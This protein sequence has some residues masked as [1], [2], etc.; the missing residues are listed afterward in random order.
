MEPTD[1]GF[2]LS[3]G[4]EFYAYAGILGL[5]EDCMSLFYGFDGDVWE[6]SKHNQGSPHSIPFTV[7]ERREIA[8]YMKARWDQWATKEVPSPHC[9]HHSHTLTVDPPIGVERCCW[10]GETREKPWEFVTHAS[11]GPFHK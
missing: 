5:N 2:K 9:W 10:C 7:E 3:T 11:H 4:R 1:E 8:D 6:G